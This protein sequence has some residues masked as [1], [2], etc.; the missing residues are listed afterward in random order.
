MEQNIEELF[1]A[2]Q[3]ND[4]ELIRSLIKSGINVTSY[5]NKALLDAVNLGS[6]EIID[7]LLMNGA[8]INTGI[9]QP[10]KNVCSDG[11]LKLVKYLIKRG[12]DVSADDN[13]SLRYAVAHNHIEIVKCLIDNEAKVNDCELIWASCLD[14][15]DI[16]K[17]L[18]SY[19]AD[20]S[21]RDNSAIMMAKRNGHNEI[22]DVLLENGAEFRKEY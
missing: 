9:G 19:G 6:T 16:V 14:Y 18:I 10:L 5:S 4:I 11:N 21:M 12:A 3:D 15:L 7:I 22:V 20:V 13:R 17:Y 8:D 2:I 1:K